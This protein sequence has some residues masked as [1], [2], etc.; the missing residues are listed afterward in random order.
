MYVPDG[1]SRFVTEI[2]F[3]IK[4]FIDTERVHMPETSLTLATS[5]DA[6]E[7][8]YSPAGNELNTPTSGRLQVVH[9]RWMRDRTYALQTVDHPLQ[10]DPEF[11]CLGMPDTTSFFSESIWPVWLIDSRVS[12]SIFSVSMI[13]IDV[14][15]FFGW[16][17]ILELEQAIGEVQ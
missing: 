13:E 7:I 2:Y 5:T 8:Q 4:S 10:S 16:A 3:F 15:Q 12:E 9:L 17:T 11:T 6:F 14:I 1:E